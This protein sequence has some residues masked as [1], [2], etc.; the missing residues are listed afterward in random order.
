MRTPDSQRTGV[1]TALLAFLI[2]GFSP[3]YY[4]AV[5]SASSLEILSHRAVWSLLFTLVLILLSGQ[6]RTLYSLFRKPRLLLLLLVSA[7]LLGV[8]WLAFIW[9][10]N[11]GQALEAS[12]GYFIFPI[13]ML[14]LGG[15]FL[16]E[17]LNPRQLLAVALV[18]L[19]VL[20]L[21]IMQHQLPW[22]ALLLATTMGFYSL[23]RKWIPVDSL[24]GLTVE[25]LLLF[26]AAVLYLVHLERSGTLAFG[27]RGVALDLLL[28][29]S[30]LVTALPLLLY[31]F[32]TRRLRLGTVGLIQ[33]LSPT[34]Q[35]LLAVL[36]FDEPFTR[37]H[38]YTFLL[39]WGGLL[40]FS[41]DSHRRLRRELRTPPA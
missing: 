20:N 12:M 31:N 7:L 26:P 30:A 9:A 24:V 11:N 35:F 8:N 38:L 5:G 22:I 14:L 1:I 27:S 6:H 4:R 2:W 39:I 25:C 33:Y 41:L 16:G 13:V 10:V 15:V 29:A 37:P 17:Q 36:L 21:L 28:A 18:L 32:S 19:G 34:C 40:L 3:L 23:L